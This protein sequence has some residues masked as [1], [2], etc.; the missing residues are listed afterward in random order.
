[1]DQ[2]FTDR[3]VIIDLD[4][5]AHNLRAARRL[6]GGRT[7]IMAVVKADAY[8]H[9]LVPVARRLVAEGAAALGVGRVD[10]VEALRRAGLGVP[11]VILSGVLPQEA[12]KAVRLRSLPVIFDLEAAE[13]TAQAGQR[14]GRQAQCLLKVD[15]GLGRLGFSVDELD[16]LAERLAA[17]EGLFVRGLVTHLAT[18]EDED[19][20]YALKQI[21]RF[22]GAL[23]F[24]KDRGFDFDLNSAANSAGVLGLTAS[25]FDLVRPGVMLYGYG[26]DGQAAGTK[27]GEELKPVMTFKTRLIQ[28]REVPAQT[29]VS[30]GRTYTTPAPARLGVIPLGYGQ[31]LAR[32]LSNQGAML[33][34]GRRAPIRGRVC[35]TS[36][37]LDLTG[38]P[39]T[40]AGDEVVVM[41]RQGQ[42]ALWA[43]E[44]A[45]AA[46]TICQ[47]VLCLLGSLNPRIYLGKTA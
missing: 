18:A 44:V 10:E 19:K 33:V 16:P 22:Q 43:D 17:L 37:V 14:L 34:Q 31:G 35:M 21:D 29:S 41:G 12:E 2:N 3:Q 40:Q 28:V 47:E 39:E 42:E 6:T 27:K 30:Y 4:A 38:L 11:V 25:H 9:G 15:T 5:L 7:K 8:S 24:F 36:T 13:A 20:T 26:P 45:K 1:M 46:G 23:A 32:T